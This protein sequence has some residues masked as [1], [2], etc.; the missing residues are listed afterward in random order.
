MTRAIEVLKPEPAFA[1]MFP[2]YNKQHEGTYLK[3]W[4]ALR[5][6]LEKPVKIDMSAS[7]WQKLKTADGKKA[8]AY[9][10]KNGGY[11]AGACPL[12]R[13]IENGDV[14][15]SAEKGVEKPSEYNAIVIDADGPKD[16]RGKAIGISDDFEQKL[17]EA[18]DGV[19]YVLHATISSNKEAKRR[20]IVVP[21][22]VPVTADVREAF[23]RYLGAKV[24]IENID[25]AC[26]RGK[27]L[28]CFPVYIDDD[29][30]VHNEGKMLNVAEWLPSGWENVDSWPQWPGVKPKKQRHI[31]SGGRKVYEETGE[32]KPVFDK[33]KIHNAFN[34]TY[35]ISDVL[36][37]SGKYEQTDNCRWSHLYDAAK[38]GIKVTNDAILYSYYGN[39][40]LS[41]DG[42]LDAFETA[43]VLFHG[44]LDDKKAWSAMYADAMADE[45]VKKTLLAEVAPDLPED[46]E[47]WSQLYDSTEEGIAQRCVS[48]F[49]HKTRHGKWMKYTNG[50]YKE[51]KPEAILPDVLR[52]VRIASA[53]QPED[54]E[55]SAMLGKK[56]SAQNIM[57]IWHGMLAENELPEEAWENKPW[58]MHFTDFTINLKAYCE[59]QDF[60]LEHSPENM[61]TQTT[62]YPW[63]DVENIDPNN[64][65]Y[66]LESI[67]TYLPEDDLREYFQ[68]SM[69]R[70]LV[71]GI[72]CAED[73]CVWMLSAS[74]GRDGGNGKSTLL[75]G[76]RGAMGGVG[77][78]SYFYKIPGRY[79][80]YSSNDRDA[81]APTS[82]LAGMRDKRFVQFDEYD[83]IR[84]LDT[85]KYKTFTSA[86]FLTARKMRENASEFQAKCCVFLDTNGMPGLQR[87]EYAILRRSRVVP[88]RAKL[89]GAETI[90]AQWTHNHDIHV[91]VM[92]WLLLG[93]KNWYDN[94]CKLDG[95]IDDK[96]IPEET[97]TETLSWWKSFESPEDFF[98]DYYVITNND[99]DYILPDECYD[100]YNAQVYDRGATMHAFKQAE[101]RWLREH[102]LGTK[103][104]RPGRDGVRRMYYVGVRLNDGKEV[105]KRPYAEIK[106]VDIQTPKQNAVQGE[107]DA[108][109]DKDLVNL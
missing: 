75:Y 46:A 5:E 100:A 30:Y 29:Y 8:L 103:K 104:K 17:A 91:A 77:D 6:R 1:T 33:N 96:A 97:Y 14:R 53:L 7:D 25:P 106:S 36:R 102:G 41:V 61:L 94:G 42:D 99:K 90:K 72:A 105:T 95:G 55:I 45:A 76:V 40:I 60:K 48:M 49:P 66:V 34:K 52:V 109:A 84:T 73:K 50:I 98:D 20:R 31:A 43:L 54:A 89:Q 87:R 24:G 28:A 67:K 62:S 4:N 19:E 44:P 68:R 58:L 22:A 79:L 37:K 56:N 93:L 81:E 92:A 83:G 9:K 2:S 74:A 108:F 12:V 11:I 71:G 21:V 39:D 32:W 51:V 47:T 82:V 15:P 27:Q 85:E 80:Y 107:L 101:S 23:V 13:N 70:A 10:F 35:R 57:T 3:D 63:S 86:G 16:E 69:G 18:L 59:G 26:V 88:F 38:D 65:A 64:F 78:T